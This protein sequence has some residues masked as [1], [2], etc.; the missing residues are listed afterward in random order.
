VFWSFI[1]LYRGELYDSILKGFTK[2]GRK[3]KKQES[4]MF[5]RRLKAKIIELEKAASMLE[6]EKQENKALSILSSLEREVSKRALKKEAAEKLEDELFL[7]AL[8]EKDRAALLKQRTH[9]ESCT[10]IKGYIARRTL[11]EQEEKLHDKVDG[12]PE[13]PPCWVVVISYALSF[14]YVAFMSFYIVLFGISTLFC[15]GVYMLVSFSH[16]CVCVCVCHQPKDP[17]SRFVR[18]VCVPWWLCV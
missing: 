16:V 10:G 4:E 6:E 11:G 3:E 9:A 8:S 12:P 17:A 7:D 13:P 14:S 18:F 2:E 5:E 15:G 1:Q